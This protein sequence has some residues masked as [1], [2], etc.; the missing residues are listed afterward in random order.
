MKTRAKMTADVEHVA[1]S[2]SGKRREE[3]EA[4]AEEDIRSK[5]KKE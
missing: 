3:E 2:L 1:G 5:K 4:E